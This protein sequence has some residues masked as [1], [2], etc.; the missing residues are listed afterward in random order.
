[1]HVAAVMP[2]T[3]QVAIF[4]ESAAQSAWQDPTDGS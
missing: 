2:L 1:M 3:L 4:M